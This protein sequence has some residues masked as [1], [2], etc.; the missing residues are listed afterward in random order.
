MGTERFLSIRSLAI[1]KQRLYVPPQ[2][3]VEF[4]CSQS[5]SRYLNLSTR[6]TTSS[7]EQQLFRPSHEEEKISHS[8]E[9]IV[10]CRSYLKQLARA[11]LAVGAPSHLLE[12]YMETSSTALEID[13]DILYLPGSI[14]ISTYDRAIIS[15]EVTLVHESQGVNISKLT[16][17][18]SIYKCVIHGAYLADEG[19]A[20]LE[21]IITRL[22]LYPTS[23]RIITYGLAAVGVGPWAFSARPID[24]GSIFLLGYVLGFLELVVAP[25]SHHFSAVF[26][27]LAC[28]LISFVARGLGSIY[29]NNAPIFCF[30]AI[31]Q[32]SIVII[33]SGY[34]ILCA[35]LEL[36]NRNLMAESVRMV[37]VIIYFLS[38]RSGCLLVQFS[39][40]RG[41]AH[42]R[43]F[44]T[45]IF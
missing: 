35:A 12:E 15:T 8:I 43:C 31:A 27:V 19:S 22:G 41:E 36:Q 39:W 26:E 5:P 3:S 18:V 2:K 28:I 29:L 16:D 25:R 40:V 33:L 37:Y 45:H 10:V 7:I 20:K 4:T 32:S 6:I 24:F 34:T 38:W 9:E 21:K 44:L 13:G 1:F 42:R 14:F 17:V 11:L 30:S 23:L